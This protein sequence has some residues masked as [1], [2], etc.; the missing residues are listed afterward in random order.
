[1]PWSDWKWCVRRLCVPGSP[2][3]T[4]PT[5]SSLQTST[6]LSSWKL[7]SALMLDDWVLH[8]GPLAGDRVHQQ[9]A[10]DG[11]GGDRGV[12]AD[13]GNPSTPHRRGVQGSRLPADSPDG[14]A[15]EKAEVGKVAP[16]FGHFRAQ[17]PSL[18]C[19]T[20]P[21]VALNSQNKTFCSL[22]F[23]MSEQPVNQPPKQPLKRGRLISCSAVVPHLCHHC[24]TKCTLKSTGGG[25]KINCC[26]SIM[27]PE[28]PQYVL[29]WDWE[30]MKL[31]RQELEAAENVIEIQKGPK[32]D[33]IDFAHRL[34]WRRSIFKRGVCYLK[35]NIR[36]WIFRCKKPL[37]IA[38]PPSLD[39]LSQLLGV[40]I[41]INMSDSCFIKINVNVLLF[42]KILSVNNGIVSQDDSVSEK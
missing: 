13:G 21:A 26:A 6:L 8:L 35:V 25:S 31:K 22:V 7:R 18:L 28:H 15:Q 3:T 16:W 24:L 38:H 36:S 4:S 19:A 41:C 27:P 10:R 40:S 1:M 39:R 5:F 32:V 17:G 11:R 29:Y 9:P 23:K 14:P 20:N 12:E 42:F 30:M 33:K 37:R 2:S 34:H